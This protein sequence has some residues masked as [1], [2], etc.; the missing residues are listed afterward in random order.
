MPFTYNM[1]SRFLIYKG[2]ILAAEEEETK[3]RN[4]EKCFQKKVFKKCSENKQNQLRDIF[5]RENL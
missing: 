2:K 5:H 3:K 1:Y 4:V